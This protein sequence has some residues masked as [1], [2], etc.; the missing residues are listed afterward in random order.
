MILRTYQERDIAAI[1]AQFAQ[2]KRRIC[3]AA[4][5]GSGKTVLFV[6]AA[7]KAVEQGHRVAILVHR[8]ELVA[9]TCEA[10]AVEGIEYGIIAAGYPENSDALVRVCMVQ[11][12][13]RRPERLQ[14]VKF[15][16]VDE[17]HHILAA[18]WFEL[19]AAVPRPSTRWSSVPRSRN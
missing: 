14:G 4:P 10:L 17:A 18:T 13:V 8:Q 9:Q 19:A 16:I 6:H 15:L 11:T 5:T 7:R 3:Y 12:L 2:G 1:R